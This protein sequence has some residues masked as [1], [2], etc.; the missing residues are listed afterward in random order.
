MLAERFAR[1]EIDQQEYQQRLH[2]ESQQ[3]SNRELT[4]PKKSMNRRIMRRS[5]CDGARSCLA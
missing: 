3:Q 4:G 2:P 5:Q 1:V